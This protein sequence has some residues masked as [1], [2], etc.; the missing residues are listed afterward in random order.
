MTT[1]L[2]W[3]A[4]PAEPSNEDHL[5]NMRIPLTLWIIHRDT[6]ARAALA[7]IA[8]AE[9]NAVL[10]PP[11][12]PIFEST[13]PPNVVLLAPSR[14]FESELEFVHRI[15]PRLHQCAWIV[16]PEAGDLAEAQRLFDTLPARFLHFPPQPEPLQRTI[17]EALHRRRTD[18]LSRRRRRDL[19]TAR[20]SRWFADLELPALLRTVDPHLTRV[21]LLIRG[22][23]GT[24]RGLLAHYVHAFSGNDDCALGH[25]PCRGTETREEL[26]RMIRT[27]SPDLRDGRQTLWLENVNQ[28]PQALQS[29]VR[30]WVEYGL[31]QGTVRSHN[32]RWIVSTQEDPQSE[33]A[34]Q[35]AAPRIERDLADA[36][37]GLVVRLPPLRDRRDS[38]DRFVASTTAAWS[39]EQRERERTFSP[40]ALEALRSHVWPSNMAEAEAVVHRSLALSSANPL[41]AHDLQFQTSDVPWA[42]TPSLFEAPLADLLPDPPFAQP[43]SE[44]ATAPDQPLTADTP[45]SL[46]DAA[47]PEAYEDLTFSEPPDA[48]PPVIEAEPIATVEL[49]GPDASDTEDE[50]IRRLVGAMAHEI[51]NPLVSIRT[52]SELLPENFDDDEFRTRF[53]ELVGADVGQIESVVNQLQDLSQLGEPHREEFDLATMIDVI[54]DGERETVKDRNLLVLKELDRNRPLAIG[55]STQLESAFKSLIGKVLLLAPARGDVYVASKHNADGLKGEESMRVLLRYHDRRDSI[56]PPSN[57]EDGIRVEGVS[58]AETSLDFLVAEVIINAQGGRITIDTTDVRE[59]I[60]VIDLP[61]PEGY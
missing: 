40:M 22:E 20:F 14:D 21:P 60:V 25:V 28:L 3:L 29:Q 47:A 2:R 53:A 50:N 35:D 37:S 59:T 12:D 24:G 61:A 23:T 31:P 5:D 1:R 15:S 45:E 10:G 41:E 8:G 16:L 26:L 32:V 27:S 52:F 56:L 43:V 57:L 48:M 9:N 11:G 19:L 34:A 42:S 33:H 58:Q 55:D 51:R 18:S 17:D 7:R 44:E 49:E 36:L 4:P 46:E 6:R 30:D 13:P 54:L 39:N 38:I